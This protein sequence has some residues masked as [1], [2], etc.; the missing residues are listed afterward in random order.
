MTAT[1]RQIRIETGARLHFGLLDTTAP[2]GG[3]G[4]MIDQPA[5]CIELA[6]HDVDSI[7]PRIARRAAP[8]ADRL[9]RWIGIESLPPVTIQMLQSAPAHSGLGSGT[10]LSLAIAEGLAR[11]IGQDL[12]TETLACQI[13]DRG[14]RSAVGVHGYF[15]GGLIYEAAQAQSPR[16]NPVRRRI[17]LPSAWRIV[18]LRPRDNDATVSGAVERRKFARLAASPDPPRE[19]LQQVLTDQLLP[20]AEQGDFDAFTAAVGRYNHASGMLFAAAQGGPYNGRVVSE[21]VA[22]L[23]AA[24]AAG[25]GQSSWGPGV[26]AWCPDQATAKHLAAQFGSASVATNVVQVKSDGRKLVSA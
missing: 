14:K 3:L 25:V 10:Q 12:P 15:A 9:R 19:Q 23:Q 16:L 18:V 7:D 5:T 2:F 6:L 8:I 1:P 20:A 22:K 13:A 26:F 4:V 24:G 21:L 17:Q 11:L